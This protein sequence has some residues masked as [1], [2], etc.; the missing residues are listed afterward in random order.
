MDKLEA[1]KNKLREMTKMCELDEGCDG[2]PYNKECYEKMGF[3]EPEFCLEIIENC[4]NLLNDSANLSIRPTI[5][6]DWVRGGHL[7]EK[8]NEEVLEFTKA[9]TVDNTIEEFWDVVQCL[10]NYID[11]I[12][13]SEEMIMEGLKVHNE[14]LLKRG[15]KF[16]K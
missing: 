8:L 5:Q 10:V 6:K 1:I 16:K 2:C 13:I 9:R 7:I 15:W 11:Y 14:K 3:H 12:G 4:E